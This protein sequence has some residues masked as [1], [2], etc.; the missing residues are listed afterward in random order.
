MKTKIFAFRKIQ[1]ISIDAQVINKVNELV[2]EVNIL[3]EKTQ[4]LT[5]NQQHRNAYD[6]SKPTKR[7]EQ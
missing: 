3:R 4:H 7:T 1:P 2:D 5:I 6:L